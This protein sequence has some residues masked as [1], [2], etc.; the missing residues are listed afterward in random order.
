[1]H[2][3]V[4]TPQEM[5][6]WPYFARYPLNRLP[7]PQEVELYRILTADDVEEMRD[8]GVY[9]FYRVGIGQDGTWHYF[10]AGE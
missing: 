10:V 2:V 1:M 6:V 8:F 3:D 9:V 5:Y 4:G 7:P